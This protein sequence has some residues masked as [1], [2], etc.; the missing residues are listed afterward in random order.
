M[1]LEEK[2]K[3]LAAFTRPEDAR[4]E[5][6]NRRPLIDQFE[7]AQSREAASRPPLAALPSDPPAPEDGSASLQV[8]LAA[9]RNATRLAHDRIAELE[10]DLGAAAS[11]A[12]DLARQLSSFNLDERLVQL[13]GERDRAVAAEA[14]AVRN[15]ELL[16]GLCGVRGIDPASA[17]QSQHDASFIGGGNHALDHWL[18]EKNA[19]LKTALFRTH[20]AEIRAEALRRGAEIQIDLTT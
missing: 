3:S 7:I 13:A 10:R 18:R 2:L 14:L 6:G 11:R 16:E 19:T 12:D 15:T 8:L 4:D 20:K 5:E 1:N 9:E 17:V